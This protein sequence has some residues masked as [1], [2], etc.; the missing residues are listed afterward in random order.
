MRTNNQIS[1]VNPQTRVNTPGRGG[2]KAQVGGDTGGASET[3]E[4]DTS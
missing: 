2:D 1:R 3:E 4:A